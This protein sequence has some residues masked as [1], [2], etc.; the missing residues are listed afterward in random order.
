M[1][2]LST[3]LA[4][5]QT[6]AMARLGGS[7]RED[8]PLAPR[9]GQDLERGLSRMRRRELVCYGAA[10]VLL[11]AL[12]GALFTGTGRQ[13][14]L[15]GAVIAGMT[16]TLDYLRRLSRERNTMDL[17]L[18]FCRSSDDRTIAAVVTRLHQQ[19]VPEPGGVALSFDDVLRAHGAAVGLR[20]DR[21]RSALFGGIDPRIMSAIPTGGSPSGQILTDLHEL[22]RVGAAGDG[23][24]PLRRWLLNAVTLSA[25]RMERA[26]FEGCL[27]KLDGAVTA[28]AARP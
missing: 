19:R 24:V 25:A 23:E 10:G 1:K 7:S 3:I 15:G 16:W 13:P 28:V 2:E 21:E 12:V 11:A 20:F 26:T 8:G 4:R 27:R 18:A 5:Y 6:S 17:L 14:V 9:L 22:N